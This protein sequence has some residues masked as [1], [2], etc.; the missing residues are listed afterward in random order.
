MTTQ[1][2]ALEV[3]N[4]WHATHAEI[5]SSLAP[6]HLMVQ[7]RLRPE[8]DLSGKRVLEIGCGLGRF[9]VW[10]ASQPNRPT[11]IN[12]GDF[13]PVA[14]EN[15]KKLTLPSESAEINWFVGDIEN[16]EFDDNSLDTIFSFETIE[17]VPT[18]S[19][20]VKELARVLK[21]GG[22]IYLTTPNYFGL[23]GLYRVYCYLRG[24][25]FD[26]GG[27]PICHVTMLQTTRSW[28]REAGL[29]IVESRSIGQYVPIPGRPPIEMAWLDRL[30]PV[31]RHFGLHS[32]VIG[33][34]P[35]R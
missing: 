23:F 5:N 22:R 9:A 29:K 4:R 18:P 16:L 35:N 17:H 8:L 13:S 6:W 30:E 24:K 31:A 27:Q 33:E 14:V 20:A 32:M 25:K 21:P 7:R 11:E 12:A 26:E 10:L 19:K 1:P 15:G 28:F 2:D 3:Y 34:K